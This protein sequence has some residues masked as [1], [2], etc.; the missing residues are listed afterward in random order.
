VFSDVS[1][2]S[3]RDDAIERL[4]RASLSRSE[5]EDLSPGQCVDAEA[6]A[7]WAEG[8]LAGPARAR[9]ESHAASC[10]RCLEIIVAVSRT[11]PAPPAH[12]P[13][14]RLSRIRWLV[15][16]TA[17]AAAVVL[18]FVVPPRPVALVEE[19]RRTAAR[20]EPVVAPPAPAPQATPPPLASS[21]DA[22]KRESGSSPRT[23]LKAAAAPGESRPA[24]SDASENAGLGK[25]GSRGRPEPAQPAN[26]L[27]DRAASAPVAS[28]PAAAFAP[29]DAAL[30][31]TISK[32]PLEVR[33]P[34]PAV[35]WRFV[36]PGFV[37]RSVD[38][39]ASWQGHP[40]GVAGFLMAG[41]SPSPQVCWAVGRSGTVLLTTD[42][43]RWQQ[44]T[45]PADVD[46]VSIDATDAR[47][48]V[49][50]ARDGRMFRTTNGGQS[51]Q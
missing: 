8:R 28:A 25:E 51:W 37:E 23:A 24:E 46:L 40:T 29:A 22:L 7:A 20:P 17:V 30:Q 9:F 1:R 5:T 43:T 2:E 38:G 11:A 19:A 36:G 6:A 31:E 13:W 18:W 33:S 47:T 32:A 4:L 44:V 10:P 34:D 39:G 16:A 3:D 12:Q 26:R 35:R 41:A 15:P 48:A 45:S 42:G 21:E 14:W 49:V 50:T 27:D